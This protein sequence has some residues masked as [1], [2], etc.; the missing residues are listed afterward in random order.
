MTVIGADK[1]MKNLYL[2]SKKFK[3]LQKK[4]NLS[5]DDI[6]KSGAFIVKF[7]MDNTKNVII[8]DNKF[9]VNENRNLLFCQS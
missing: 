4:Y 7:Y 2:K 9:P 8:I 3:I 5:D 1:I 6:S